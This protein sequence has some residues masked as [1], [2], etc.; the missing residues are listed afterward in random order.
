MQT[1]L[2]TSNQ[3]TAA[4]GATPIANAAGAPSELFT[5][6]LVA[7][8]KNQNPL[9]PSDPSQ[10]VNQ[11]TQLSQMESLQKLA[12]QGSANAAL[13]QS[14]QAVALGA[15]VGS[16]V[17]VRSDRV[18]LASQPVE[19]GFSLQSAS[20]QVTAV[21]TGPGGGEHRIPLGPRGAGDARFTLDPARLGLAPGAYSLRIETDSKETPATE[22]YGQLSSVKVAAT[23]SVMLNV[24]QVGE[25]LPT[26]VTQFN[27]RPA[28]QAN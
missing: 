1:S 27:G 13:L 18:N 25:V 14:M 12:Q 6:L 16:Q 20:S 17:A 24:A 15:Q 19:A 22:V 10:F 21:L 9:E 5:K 23:G 2:F 4:E 8:I 26:A 11:L 3:N 7:Q 28:A